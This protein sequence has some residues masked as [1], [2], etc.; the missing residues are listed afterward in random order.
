MK[1]VVPIKD[2]LPN[3]YQAR[4]TMDREAIRNLAE[5]M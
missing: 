4:K 3:P 5:E 2:V 1:V